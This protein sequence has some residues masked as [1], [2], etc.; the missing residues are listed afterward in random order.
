MIRT[1]ITRLTLGQQ[2]AICAAALSLAVVVVLAASTA[3]W[4][5]RQT[6]RLVT[7][8][9]QATA[10]VL[11]D[12]LQRSILTRYREIRTFSQLD[13]LR[14]LWMDNPVEAR[15]VLNQLQESYPDY[16]WIGFADLKGNVQVATRGMLEGVSVAERPWF[17]NGLLG[18]TLE[19][20]HEAQLLQKLLGLHPS[21]EPFRFIDIAFP[22]YSST[23]EKIGVLGA[24]LSWD[25]ANTLSRT[26]LDDADRARGVELLILARDGRA[27]LGAAMNS[28][29]YPTDVITEIQSTRGGSF[30]ATIGSQPVIGAYAK[31]ESNLEYS[32]LGWTVVAQQASASA[33]APVRNLAWNIMVVG[34]LIAIVAVILATLIGHHIARPLRALTTE[35]DKLGRTQG[36]LMISRYTGTLEVIQL[37]TALRS[38]LRRIGFAEQRTQEAEQRASDGAQQYLH[39]IQILRRMADT[40]P[41]TNLMNR[42]SF[43]AAAADAMEYFRRYERPI[44]ALIV[45]I[46]HFKAVNDSHGHAAGDAVIKRTSELIQDTLRSTDKLARFGGEEFVVML[47][48]VDEEGAHASAKRIQEIIAT[49]PIGY[50]NQWIEIT[51]SI[52][53]TLVAME[54]RDFQD[55]I[56]R[57]DRAL[58]MAKNTGRDRAFYLSPKYEAAA[59]RVA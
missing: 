7:Q 50:G 13:P 30:E 19:D 39:D 37:S 24:H 32:D 15:N 43:L 42:R 35:A 58:Y 40:D 6:Y 46:D 44:A 21:G 31:V 16:S 38:L 52:G 2:I 55:A 34:L 51:V 49:N 10:R 56:E 26:T 11:A 25:F 54:D 27:I 47:R 45:D 33:L 36:P 22:V 28:Q 9:L 41:L 8:D 59:L 14:H 20:I 17:K 53:V 23:G 1:F 12:R 4:G 3:Y 48:E 57:A 18:P 5:A 29:A